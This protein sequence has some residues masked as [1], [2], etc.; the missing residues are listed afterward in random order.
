MLQ[1]FTVDDALK[2]KGIRKEQ[3]ESTSTKRNNCSLT[4][5]GQQDFQ[6]PSI[7]KSYLVIPFRQT[8]DKDLEHYSI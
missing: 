3:E 1:T 7:T 5:R 2:K 6:T 4:F 8:L